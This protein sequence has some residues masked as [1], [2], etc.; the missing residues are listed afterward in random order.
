MNNQQPT[1]LVTGGAGFIGANFITYFLKKYPDHQLI[2]LDKLTYAGSTAN[3][4]EVESL[5]NYHFINDDIANQKVISEIFASFDIE[6]AINFAAESHVDRSIQDAKK[7]IETNVLGTNAL[8]QTAKAAWSKQGVLSNRRF[9]QISTDEVYGSLGTTGKFHENTPYDPRNPYSA[10]KASANLLVKSFGYTYGMNVVIS[11]S[12]NNFGPKQHVEKLIP[13]I[14]SK[15][16]ALQTIPIYG[17][18]QNIRDW[19][20]VE[21]H[22]RALD[23]IYHHGNTLETYNIGG[24]NERTNIEIAVT[25]CEILDQLKPEL[26]ADTSIG[27]YKELITFTEDR[28]GHDRRYAV[29]DTKLRKTL[30]WEPIVSLKTGLKQT[31]DWYVNQWNKI[32]L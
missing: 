5:D 3:C 14:I 25:V 4:R 9:H 2:N 20:Y 10:S 1:L 22:C 28:Q 16:L 7:F 15:A 13:T 23:L 24:S 17:D 31:V 12:S 21:D 6:G 30:G 11:S 27:S 18:G 26:K 19:L 29:D 32:A 8:L